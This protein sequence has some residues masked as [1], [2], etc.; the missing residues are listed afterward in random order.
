MPRDA[1]AHLSKHLAANEAGFLGLPAPFATCERSDSSRQKKRNALNSTRKRTKSWTSRRNNS[2][3]SVNYVLLC[4]LLLQCAVCRCEKIYRKS[5][6]LKMKSKRE[7]VAPQ[8]LVQPVK[9]S[10]FY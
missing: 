4:I 7:P 2:A 1:F 6:N 8:L 10:I 9:S 5:A 3:K